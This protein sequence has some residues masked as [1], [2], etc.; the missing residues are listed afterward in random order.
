[1]QYLLEL[2]DAGSKLIQKFYDDI[3][4]EGVFTF[5]MATEEFISTGVTSTDEFPSVLDGDPVVKSFRNMTIQAGHTVRPTNRCKGMYLYI[6]GDLIIDGELTMTA[7]GANA[8]GKFV[9]IDPRRGVFINSED[10]FTALGLAVIQ[11]TG[12]AG[13]PT[14]RIGSGN[15]NTYGADGYAG[16]PGIN[17]A[18]G[19]GGGGGCA[20][21][22]AG[23]STGGAGSAG[24][25][26]SGGAGGGGA[27]AAARTVTAGSGQ[28]NGG[29]GGNGRCDTID[30]YSR[31][32]AAGGGAGNPGG[33]GQ[34]MAP[35]NYSAY[36]GENGTGGLLI[37]V[38]HGDIIFGPAGKI[39]SNGSGGGKGHNASGGGSGGG[40]IH[41]F[42]KGIITDP[43]KIQAQG[44]AGAT[45]A[46][47]TPYARGG[48]GG[49]GSIVITKF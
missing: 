15:D 25:S 23:Y 3:P 44:G 16:S 45:S 48:N 24:T 8:P 46:V 27:T 28:P 30:V 26:F 42:H 10:I 1:M 49:A 40:A 13:A 14:R 38:V 29:S 31:P 32:Q 34:R 4:A 47:S 37:L 36:S 22:Q 5:P 39:T 35:S 12:G 9:G 43:T 18:C 20:H 11:P 19:G 7:R 33:A 41:I 21:R 6:A 17:G 2:P